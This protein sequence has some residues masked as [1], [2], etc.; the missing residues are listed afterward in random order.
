[1]PAGNTESAF[2]AVDAKQRIVPSTITAIRRCAFLITDVS[3][4][5]PNV[6]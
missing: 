1:L 3:D 4:P 6:Y 2:A 5:R